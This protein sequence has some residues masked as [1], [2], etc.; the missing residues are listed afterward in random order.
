MDEQVQE[1]Q[2]QSFMEAADVIEVKMI[3]AHIVD[4]RGVYVRSVQV[5]ENGP[6]PRGAVYAP[7]LLSVKPGNVEKWEEDRWVQVPAASLP[8]LPAIQDFTPVPEV[9]AEVARWQ[10]VRALRLHADPHAPERNCLATV[11][12]LRDAAPELQRADIDDALQAV[13]TWRRQS[14]TLQQIAQ[15]AGWAPEFVDT[16]FIAAGGY[17]L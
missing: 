7:R 12:A 2:Q 9:P 17:D 15:A 8:Q 14:P 11:H 6:Q 4:A 1:T 16:L 10:A 3:S 5:D 13:L